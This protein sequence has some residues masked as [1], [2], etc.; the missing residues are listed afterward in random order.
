MK[1]NYQ[2]KRDCLV[3]YPLEER[4]I[5]KMRLLRNNCREAFVY[6][7]EISCEEQIDWYQK[8]LQKDDDIMF[9]VL[10][11]GKWVGAVALYNLHGTSAEFGR[12]MIDQK[13]AGKKGLGADVT[14]CVCEIA[15]QQMGMDR[16][17]LE[18]Y[19]DN[20]PAMKTYLKVGFSQYG[21]SYDIRSKK[22]FLMELIRKDAD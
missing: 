14:R 6:S 7:D 12:L 10:C 16:I 20:I 11:R 15:F 3:L 18:V 5:E 19:A 1:H 17:R 4:D 21:V 8:Y 9:S 13:A 2:L 22:M